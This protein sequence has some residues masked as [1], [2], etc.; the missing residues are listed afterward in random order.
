MQPVYLSFM[1]WA[2]QIEEWYNVNPAI[3]AVLYISSIPPFWFG[4]YLMAKSLAKKGIRKLLWKEALNDSAF[5]AG[6][7]VLSFAWAMPVVYL[8]FWG[9]NLP[10]WIYGVTLLSVSLFALGLKKQIERKLQTKT[11]AS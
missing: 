2:N 7:C 10:V 6:L 5:N 8:I 3:Y 4:L 1:N 11:N 9:R